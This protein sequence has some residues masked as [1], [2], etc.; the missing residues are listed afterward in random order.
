MK[1][2]SWITWRIFF[3]TL[4]ID[5]IVLI[6]AADHHL[7]NWKDVLIWGGV[8]LIAHFSLAPLI[9]V[10]INQSDVWRNWKF[11]L[12][13][14]LFLGAFRGVIINLCVDWFDLHQ[15][16][17]YA[18]KIF[19]SMVATPQWFVA[20]AIFFES[21][22]EYQLTFRELFAKAM[23][24]EQENHERKRLLPTEKSSADET[25]ARLQFITSNLAN[26]IQNLLKRPRELSE[27]SLEASKIQQVIDQDIRPA[28]Q[29]LWRKNAIYS[30]RIPFKTI[31]SIS[32]LQSRLP[33]FPVVAISVP[34][35]FIGLNGA[36]GLRIALA[37]CALVTIFDA[38]IYGFAELICKL[39][40]LTRAQSNLIVL[41]LSFIIPLIFQLEY[42]PENFSISSIHSVIF[43]Y[44]LLLTSA[45]VGL[46]LTVNGYRVIKRHRNNVI[47]SLEKYLSGEKVNF[48]LSESSQ[49]QRNADIATFL[50]GEVQAGLTA[51][52]LLLQ[53]AVQNG[54]SDL[55]QEAL[56][57]AS[58]LLNQDL[59]N[60]SYTRMATPDKKISKIVDAWKGIADI[61]IKFPS[62]NQLNDDVRRNSARL[63]E[64]A[65]ANSIRH[66]KATNIKVVGVLAGDQLTL[67]IISN[68][69]PITRGK[70]GLG[71]KMFNDLTTDWN[72]S[73]E[74]GL[75]RVTLLLEN[76]V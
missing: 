51:S 4:P 55:A 27:Y 20:V 30:P 32:L 15:T 72:Y 48:I 70:A 46:L 68:G 1:R 52:S 26:D 28:S 12:L 47:A 59:S 24:K 7:N 54:D 11:D 63:I 31:A 13:Y 66:S 33:V 14:L 49:A 53:Q 16:V 62:F 41:T 29:E 75:N 60:I 67:S 34:Y 18:Y 25:I 22:R 21:K 3:V 38:L 10:G 43:F 61:S 50:H 76:R 57:R 2:T 9:I 45:F 58:G 56:E 19:N 69:K 64:E 44:Q 6:L 37:Q 39:R 65:V 35:L 74:N 71:T 23:R 17:S 8:A 42:I 36:F 40:Y 5:V 73:I